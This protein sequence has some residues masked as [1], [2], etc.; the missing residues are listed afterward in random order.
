MQGKATRLIAL[1]AALATI[2]AASAQASIPLSGAQGEPLD[3]KT[4]STHSRFHIHLDLG[5]TEHIRDLTQTLPRGMLPNLAGPTCPPASFEPADACPANTLVGTTTVLATVGPI[6]PNPLTQQTIT[7]RIYFLGPD[8]GEGLPQLGIVLDAST[9]KVF[10]K[11]KAE[12]TTQGVKTTIKN[13]PQT[14]QVMGVAVPIRIDSLDITLDKTFLAN[15]DLC[16]PATTAFSVVSY[17]DPSHT[18]TA[19]DSYTPTGCPPPPKARCGGRLVTLGGTAK[20]D[21]LQGTRGRDVIAGFGGNDTLKGLRGND[22]LCGGSG[23]DK[24]LGGPGRDRLL[25]G[26]G[27]DRLRGGPGKDTQTQ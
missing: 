27:R 19:S 6:V 10:Q 26:P 25:G 14:T 2:P 11:G 24:L 13:F 8:P 12:V 1:A 21:V 17:E 3:T 18:S 23:R 22:V 7:G 9:G 5:G 4:A 16:V 20:N 15:P